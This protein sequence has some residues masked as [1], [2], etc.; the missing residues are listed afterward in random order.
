MNCMQENKVTCRDFEK[1]QKRGSIFYYSSGKF[2]TPCLLF[3]RGS[4]SRDA[5]IAN[6]K[7]T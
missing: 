4:S 1:P 2:G 7:G 3:S 5:H 6:R